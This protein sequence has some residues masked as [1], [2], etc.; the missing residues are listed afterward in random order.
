MA[1]LKA[2][3]IRYYFIIGKIF[4]IPFFYTFFESKNR[5]FPGALKTIVFILEK[6][7][8][9][10]FRSFCL[11]LYH[12]CLFSLDFLEG[13]P[14]LIYSVVGSAACDGMPS[15]SDQL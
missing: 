3:K 14:N 4:S 9:W 7:K 1:I 8:K 11:S 10:L 13:R 6:L 12:F 15:S 5:L 2:L